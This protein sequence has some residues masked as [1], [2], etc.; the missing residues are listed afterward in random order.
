M[1]VK[2]HGTSGSGKSSIARGLMAKAKKLYFYGEEKRPQAYELHM[3]WKAPLYILGPYTNTCGGMDAIS[4]FMEQ[5]SLLKY[6]ADEG[7]VF[8]EGLLIST[9]YGAMGKLTE[10]WGNEHVFAFLNTPMELCI[11]RIKARRLERGNTK[12]LNEE[13]TRNRQ[14]PIDSLQRKLVQ[15]GR[16]VEVIQWDND[17]VGQ[18][19][20]L[21][22]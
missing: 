16:R 7:H 3:G 11:E 17:P 1:I 20:R 15:M 6:Y 4:D 8:Y 13:N 9:Y 12:P 19:A 10:K 18:I 22:E 5:E 2:L 14:K 21:Y